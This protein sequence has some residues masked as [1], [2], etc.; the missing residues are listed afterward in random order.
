MA[1]IIATAVKETL[2]GT[3]SSDDN[4][5][6]DGNKSEDENN[7]DANHDDG[8]TKHQE[9]LLVQLIASELGVNEKDIVDF[10]LNLFDVQPATLGGVRSEFVHSARLDNLASCFL[11]LR[12]LLDHVEDGGV[13]SDTDVSMIAMFDHEEYVLFFGCL[14]PIVSHTGCENILDYKYLISQS[15]SLFAYLHNSNV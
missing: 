13:E 3:G 15:T 1:P 9:P 6:G 8:W 2:D 12:G 4:K 14:Y 11:S 10:E 7:K 5:S